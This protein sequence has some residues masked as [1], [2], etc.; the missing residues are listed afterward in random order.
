MF[1]E[2][3]KMKPFPRIVVIRLVASLCVLLAAGA[4]TGIVRAALPGGVVLPPVTEPPSGEHHVGKVI[5][6]DLI[7]PHLDIAKRFY[8]GLFGWTFRDIPRDPRYTVALLDGEPVAGLYQKPVPSGDRQQPRWLA[9][10]AVKDVDAAIDSARQRGGTVVS[11]P[12]DYPQRG[13]QAVLADPDGATFAVLASGSGDPPDALAAPGD[14][15]WSALMVK[16]PAQELAFYKNLFGYEVYDLAAEGDAQHYILASDTYA[17][18]GLNALPADSQR[19]HPHWLNFLRVGDVD[20]TA[21]LAVSLGGRVLVEPRP[22]RHG[23][24]LAVLADPTGAVFGVMEWPDSESKE[25][26]Q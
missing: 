14:W 10:L 21:A 2:I 25:E 24:K 7:T 13:R 5:W 11:P 18:A 20:R 16:D 23:G 15:I 22:D 4:G 9:F 3:Q 19:R 6:A 8:G 1:M 26:P 17:R 12:R